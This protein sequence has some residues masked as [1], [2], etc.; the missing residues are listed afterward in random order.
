MHILRL[1]PYFYFPNVRITQWTIQFEP[2][3][4]M[5]IQIAEL[6]RAVDKLGIDQVVVT[7][8]VPGIEWCYPYGNNTVVQSVR[9][10]LP[11]LTSESKGLLGLLVSWG[12]G[13]LLWSIRRRLSRPEERFDLV[14][15]HCSEL[16]WTFI[17]APLVARVLKAPL[18]ITVHCSALATVYPETHLEKLYYAFGRFAEKNAIRAASRVV[19][20]TDRLRRFYIEAGLAAPE[21]INIVP[22]G[23]HCD[24]FVSSARSEAIDELR[25]AYG[26]PKDKHVVLF[27]GRIAPEK[28]WV[29]FIEAAKLLIDKGVHFLVCGDGNQRPLMEQIIAQY[30]LQNKFTVT[31]FIPHEQCACAIA[32]SEVVVMPSLHEEMGGTILETMVFGKPIVATTVGG[33]SEVVR[34][35]FN[36]WLVPPGNSVE[37]ARAVK[38]LLENPELSRSLGKNGIITVRKGF[39]MCDLASRMI[40]IYE[41]VCG[42]Q[43]RQVPRSVPPQGES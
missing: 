9:L 36:G 17:F 28:G 41:S 29:Y 2:V 19:T 26:I 15:C 14:H 12:V 24:K 31:G 32:L 34:H 16:P 42:E 21:K 23:L 20:L 3:G 39:D 35:G 10:P 18:V 7:T 40:R 25:N 27:L 8:G 43:V 37:I 5:Q 4:G 13:S 1:T 22:D 11:P 38:T 6:T 33:I 30:A